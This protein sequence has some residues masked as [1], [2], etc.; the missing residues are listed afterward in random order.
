MNIVTTFISSLLLCICFAN[1]VDARELSY[2]GIAEVGNGLIKSSTS[3]ILRAD[4]AQSNA[5]NSNALENVY[6]AFANPSKYSGD[7]KVLIGD[8]IN[9]AKDEKIQTNVKDLINSAK[10]YKDINSLNVGGAIDLLSKIIL[11]TPGDEATNPFVMP[12]ITFQD[13]KINVE[14]GIGYKIVNNLDKIVDTGKK[15]YNFFKNL[16]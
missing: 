2:Q 7:V 3:Q 15:V 12:N 11:V 8:V 14:W 1:N 10:E 6:N 16:F 9:V 5:K 13:G 4:I